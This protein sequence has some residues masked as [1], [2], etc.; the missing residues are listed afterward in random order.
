MEAKQGPA[1]GEGGPKQDRWVQRVIDRF[2]FFPRFDSTRITSVVIHISGKRGSKQQRQRRRQKA[3]GPA[4][5]T[6]ACQYWA[7]KIGAGREK[8]KGG[9][10]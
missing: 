9:L 7:T 6:R 4:A 2:C 3:S 5:C 8:G 10:D 1:A